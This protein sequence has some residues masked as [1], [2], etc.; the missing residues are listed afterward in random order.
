MPTAPCFVTHHELDLFLGGGDAGQR[1]RQRLRK[2][3]LLPEPADLGK[4]RRFNIA[5]FPRFVLAG[6]VRDL[7]LIPRA[8][9]TMQAVASA[10]LR[11]EAFTEVS[12]A[13]REVAC[14]LNVWRFDALVEGVVELAED[15]VREWDAA[16]VAA[17]RELAERLGIS[18]S[19]EFGVI[20][21]IANDVCIIALDAGGVEQVPCLRVAAAMEIGGAVALER[22]S[23]LAKEL[24]YVMPL[25]NTL[26]HD[27][28]EL[29]N[30]FAKMAAPAPTTTIVVES[31]ASHHDP[32]P[33][34][35]SQPRRARWH[36]ASTMTRVGAA[37]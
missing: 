26:D 6:L 31:E 37:G 2:A 16:V 13:V 8:P 24:G 28:G 4:V 21:R 9:E 14:A 34:R 12:A 33:Y 7:A 30:W 20:E 25:E 11:S 29:A 10:A 5:L 22:V 27:D 1:Q 19:T 35:R 23:V 17:E 3:R 32:L 36:G 15:A 18:F